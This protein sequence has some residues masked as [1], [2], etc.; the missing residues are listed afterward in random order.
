[1]S[2]PELADY[3]RAGWALVPIPPGEKGPVSAGWQTRGRCVTDPDTAEFLEGNVGLAHAY[4]GT[5]VIDIDNLGEATS[6]FAERGVNL[7]ALLEAP[8]AVMIH[9]GRPGRAK[10]LYALDKPLR[11]FKLG[12]T[13]FRCASRSGSTVQDVLPPSVH[14]DT[15]KPYEWRYGDDMLGHWSRLAP[16]PDTL[17]AIWEGLAARDK[18]PAN[19]ETPHSA[20]LG[21]VREMLFRHDPDTG[22][23]TWVQAGMALHHETGGGL[24]GLE[25]WNEWSA[26]GQKYKGRADLEA[27]W[28]SFRA[29]AE[30]PI[31]GASLRIDRAA[32]V[33]EFPLVTLADVEA[34]KL[35]PMRSPSALVEIVGKVLTRDKTGA[36]YALLSNLMPVLSVPEV[37]G[38]RL[39]YDSFKDML[40]CAPVGTD[41]WRPVK[42][43]DYTAT[44]LWL[45]TEA[46]FNPVSR[47]LVRDAIYLIAEGNTVDTAKNWLQS[48]RWDGKPRVRNFFPLYMGTIATPYEY[49]CGE[50]LWSALAARIMEPGC[51]VDM[52][53]I[54]VGAQ[55]VGKSRGVRA[56]AP[57]P[58]YFTEIRLDEHDDT[59]ARKMRGLL[60]GEI[61]ELRG[62]RTADEDAIKSF[63]TRTHEKWVPKF[64]EFAT[65]FARR[66]VF[67]ATTNDAEFLAD[68]EN[69]RWL[70]LRVSQVLV[71]QIVEDREQLWAEGLV[72]WME[73]GVYWKDA[74]TLAVEKHEDFKV[75]DQWGEI[76]EQWLKDH[77]NSRMLKTHDVLLQAI[78]LDVRHVTRAHQLRVSRLLTDL[79]YE[80]KVIRNPTTKKAERVW[81]KAKTLDAPI[82]AP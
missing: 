60:V 67:I 35:P 5:C 64:I 71:D 50:Y 18:L 70:P 65:T 17:R 42:D 8:E 33:E 66:C 82:A 27:H 26:Q 72:L 56:I 38:Q 11:S 1:M 44:R 76:V 32:E 13:E 49:A 22:Y 15:K 9:S 30:N 52:V 31:T 55:G 69:R 78:G 81:V 53:P 29:D 10:L 14:P 6:W 28:R 2:R 63:V 57:G 39:A 34:A 43:T 23:E 12:H 48:L 41:N 59:L 45:E 79:G 58:E 16:L 21:K 19:K 51:Q 61:A 3:V 36:P 46:N 24:D 75:V 40:V 77:S 4:S 73:N 54:L 47:E 37:C 62:L 20:N 80:R 7:P 25:L 74:Q 68:T